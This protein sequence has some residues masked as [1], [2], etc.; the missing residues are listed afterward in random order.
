[1]SVKK[2]NDKRFSDQVKRKVTHSGDIS[3]FLFAPKI[4]DI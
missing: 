3:I 1:M 2:L 4:S